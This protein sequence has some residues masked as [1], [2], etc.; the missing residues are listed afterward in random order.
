MHK[1]FNAGEMRTQ[2]IIKACKARKDADNYA[3]DDY[4]PLFEGQAISC[5]WVNIHGKE[6][7]EAARLD[8]K[9]AATITMRYTPLVDARCRI[10]KATEADDPKAGYDV[11][12]LDDIQDRHELLEIK[13][14]RVVKA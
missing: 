10:W 13:V 8:L 2:I 7:Y 11:V 1:R 6:V 9:E 3:K 14:K 5:K 12:S 4:V